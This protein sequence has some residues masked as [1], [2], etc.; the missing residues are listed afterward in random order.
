[1]AQLNFFTY[2]PKQTPLHRTD[3]RI[4]LFLLILMTFSVSTA[5]QIINFLMLGCLLITV[6]SIAKL[7]VIS[8]MKQI[9]PMLLILII[10]FIFGNEW[11][12]I[13][14]ILMTGFSQVFV[15]TT[16]TS[17][18]GSAIESYLRPFSFVPEVKIATM[19]QLSFMMI[20]L[21]MRQYQQTRAA[22]I[23]RAFN[24]KKKPLRLIKYTVIPLIDTTL[25]QVDEL[26]LAMISRN[27]TE[28]RTKKQHVATG[29]D[30]VV[31]SIGIG[32][33]ILIFLLEL[34]L[35]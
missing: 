24:V 17:H 30:W 28:M 31:L 8:F 35:T 1:M 12:A 26:A 27:Y 15:A 11:L 23:A 22:Q 19:I 25:K 5:T 9:K 13:K 3:P 32:I 33:F 18:I 10:L 20:P 14:L 2:A 21:M 6:W 29:K 4:K 16:T 7:P 34:L